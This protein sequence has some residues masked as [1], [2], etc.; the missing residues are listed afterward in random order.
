MGAVEE[1]FVTIKQR[2]KS[3]LWPQG[4]RLPSLAALAKECHVSR[5]TMW[6]AL[7]LLKK[8]NLVH[9]KKNGM[10]FAGP[11]LPSQPGSTPPAFAWERL[12]SRI[13]SEILA[14]VYREERLPPISKLSLRYGVA[15]NTFKKVLGSLVAD[16]LLER[17][18]S[19]YSPVKRRSRTYQPSVVL[20]GVG[21][22]GE[23]IDAGH[24]MTQ[25]ILES[26]ERESLRLGYAS[27]A[28]GFDPRSANCLAEFSS[29][30]GT[31]PAI[32][33]YIVTLWEPLD[34]TER[35]RWHDLFHFLAR[36]K[37]PV[38][39][40]DHIGNFSVPQS[41]QQHKNIRV[42][43]IAGIRAGEIMADFLIRRG[44]DH[45]AYLTTGWNNDWAQKRYNGL[46]RHFE[47]YG[48]GKCRVERYS[49]DETFTQSN[50]S[51]SVLNLT[52]NEIRALFHGRRSK[53][54]IEDMVQTIGQLQRDPAARP[55]A[56][57]SNAKTI[58]AVARLLAV[59][60]HG[61]PDP[62][63]YDFFLDQVLQYAGTRGQE[64]YQAPL[65]H[66]VLAESS[67]AMWV[68]SDDRTAH[69]AM[70]HL[71]QNN[72]R[73]PDDIAVAGFDNWPEAYEHHITTFDFDM[74]GIVLRAL[75]LI[76]DPR[77]LRDAPTINEFDGY[78]VE[79]RTTGR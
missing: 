52:G 7:G 35:R 31:I 38:I 69:N 50:L 53:Y 6:Y 78:V 3:G 43:S 65:F 70:H 47:R 45:V 72:K 67:A 26:L 63:A 59:I 44:Y 49:S 28:A 18:G 16:G 11:I 77:R 20:I 1:T 40:I 71:K 9:T 60:E 32:A 36:D 13:G 17:K 55:L 62:A 58:R 25:R 37:T 23:G 15:V 48:G 27:R 24:V 57:G 79:R 74:H 73:V 75:L 46:R 22:S 33:G 39:I 41:L 61:R 4:G 34:P 30:T 8:E 21:K 54:E 56:R 12:K 64:A 10:I 42:I 51:L 5:T 66:R 76:A 19:G 68:C 29:E 2:L 14:G